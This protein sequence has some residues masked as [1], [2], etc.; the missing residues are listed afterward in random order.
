[1]D[2]A[3]AAR[4]ARARVAVH[5]DSRHGGLA[6]HRCARSLRLVLSQ[7]DN[8]PRVRS[9]SPWATDCFVLNFDAALDETREAFGNDPS[10]WTWA[11]RSTTGLFGKRP[12]RWTPHIANE[13]KRLRKRLMPP[14]RPLLM[15]PVTKCIRTFFPSSPSSYSRSSPQPF[16]LK[17]FWGPRGLPLD[18]QTRSR[19]RLTH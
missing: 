8:A 16:R 4:A 15:R 18:F 3:A 9:W 6:V 13:Y 12:W 19:R 17:P 1:M 10:I 14:K 11:A 7:A 5:A 2:V